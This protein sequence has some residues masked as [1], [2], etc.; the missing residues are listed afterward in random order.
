[1]AKNYESLRVGFNVIKI[2]EWMDFVEL[3]NIAEVK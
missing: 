3:D 1:M 2:I